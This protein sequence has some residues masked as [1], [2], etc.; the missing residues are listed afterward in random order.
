MALL[1]AVFKVSKDRLIKGQNR[2]NYLFFELFYPHYL[3]DQICT[4]LGIIFIV[5]ALKN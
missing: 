4:L 5:F 2:C 1:K 3:I